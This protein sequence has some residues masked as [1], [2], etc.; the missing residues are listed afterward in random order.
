MRA[1]HAMAIGSLQPEACTCGGRAEATVAHDVASAGRF[2]ASGSAA[3]ASEGGLPPTGVASSGR[4]MEALDC[5]SAAWCFTTLSR[6]RCAREGGAGPGVTAAAGRAVLLV[7][8][9]RAPPAGVARG[10]GTSRKPGMPPV[11]ATTWRRP[12]RTTGSVATMRKSA[13]CRSAAISPRS[14]RLVARR[15]GIVRRRFYEV[16]ARA[17]ASTS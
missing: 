10:R 14:A 12:R 2:A 3:V 7:V 13:A 4:G 9:R 15:F 5:A 11:I 6:R 1:R 8:V 17:L 16:E